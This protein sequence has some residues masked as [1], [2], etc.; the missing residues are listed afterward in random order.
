[1]KFKYLGTVLNKIDDEVMRRINLRNVG[2]CSLKN[3]HDA[4]FFDQRFL[5][6]SL[7]YMIIMTVTKSMILGR[8]K[9]L[10]EV[11]FGELG[12]CGR[13]EIN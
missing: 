7:I 2:Y 5:R 13:M 9:K 10:A 11:K 3:Y 12:C 6:N 1:M 8:R 4:I